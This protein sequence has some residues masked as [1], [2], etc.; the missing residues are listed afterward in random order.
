MCSGGHGH[1]VSSIWS[2]ASSCEEEER[3]KKVQ[4][5]NMA[6]NCQRSVLT[7][8]LC[9]KQFGAQSKLDAHTL[10]VHRAGAADSGQRTTGTSASKK[11]RTF[12]VNF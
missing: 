9:H 4:L 2:P 3:Q 5:L 8:P 7:C 11:V 12:K 10:N 6:E 1:K